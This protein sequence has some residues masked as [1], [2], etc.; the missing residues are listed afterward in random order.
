MGGYEHSLSRHIELAYFVPLLAGHGGNTGGQSVGAVLT[1]LSTGS[2]SLKDAPYIIIKESTIGLSTGCVL[3][4]IIGPLAHYLF[5]MPIHVATVVSLT[6][7]LL[8]TMAATLA[9]IAPFACVWIG[10]DP[11]VIAAPMMTTTVDVCGLLTYFWIAGKIFR[12]Y[13]LEL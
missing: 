4:C 3:G 12:W 7:P 11:S 6:L 2:I 5:Q 13:G 1:A 8:G 10:W 9:S